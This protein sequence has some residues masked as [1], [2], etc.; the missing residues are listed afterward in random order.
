MC[1]TNFGFTVLVFIVV[2]R[3]P[4]FGTWFS[5]FVKNTNGFSDLESEVILAFPM[6]VP[7]P[8]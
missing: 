5:V 1:Q 8:L 4:S 7:I 2:R 6:W 3:F